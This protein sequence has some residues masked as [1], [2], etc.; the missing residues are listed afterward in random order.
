M[1]K[2]RKNIIWLLLFSIIFVTCQRDRILTDSVV[3]LEFSADTLSFDT[4]FSSIGSN[5]K[6]LKV[7]NRFNQTIQISKISLMGGNSSK[8][9]I[10]INGIKADELTDVEVS[11]NDSLYIF[12]EITTPLEKNI[13][14]HQDSI[15]FITNGNR[16]HVLLY[17]WGQ[18]INLIDGQV[19]KT[20][21]WNSAKPYLIFNSMLVDSLSTLTI[22]A[23]T[24]L[25]FHRNSRLYVKGSLIVK[26]SLNNEVIMQ[27][28]RLEKMYDDVPGQWDG[29]WFINGSK[30][31]IINYAIIKNAV[32]GLQVD[33]FATSNKPT[34][35]IHNSRVEHHSYAGILG[36]GSKILATNCVIGDCGYHSVALIYGG[37]YEFYH[38]SIANFWNNSYS[39]RTKPAVYLNNY[40]EYN[41][42]EIARNLSKAYFGNCIIYGN[43]NEEIGLDFTSKADANFFFEN[44][45]LKTNLLTE[46]NIPVHSINSKMNKDP[47]FVN[48]QKYNFELDT[49]SPAKNAGGRTLVNQ[50]LNLLQNDLLN[51]SRINDEAPDLGAYESKK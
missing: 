17:A 32:I 21:T 33:T 48:Y 35:S 14:F 38:C 7:Y 26:G 50:F 41:A 20:Q 43:K 18:N 23:G 19:I 37:E 36:R 6:R 22:E 45:L 24:K 28:D 27:G 31:N 15:V 40:Y 9:R 12:I 10:N 13:V 1:R 2:F 3:K 25:Y 39:N 11:A 5:T 49:L 8:F 30:E 51:R 34:L 44:C 29:I 47:K 46:I 42:R 16:Q 4:L